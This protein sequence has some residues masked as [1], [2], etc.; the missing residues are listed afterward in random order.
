MQNIAAR[1]QGQV[2]RKVRK[3]LGQTGEKVLKHIG[4]EKG[5]SGIRLP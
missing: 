1:K 5:Q 2:K 3:W 4:I